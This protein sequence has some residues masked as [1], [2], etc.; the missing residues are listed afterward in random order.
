MDAHAKVNQLILLWDYFTC[1]ILG[2]L[3]NGIQK[4]ESMGACENH[5][6]R[7]PS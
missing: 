4:E 7:R 6:L 1:K 2:A 5:T 3:Y